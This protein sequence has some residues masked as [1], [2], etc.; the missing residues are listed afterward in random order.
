MTEDWQLLTDF[1]PARWQELAI[2]TDATKG[3]RKN[4]PIDNLLRVLLIHIACGCSLRETV[5]RAKKAQLAEMSDVALLKRLR[6]CKEWL[7]S[8]CIEIFIE[9]GV[10]INDVDLKF[11]LF[12]ATHVQEPGK[13][14]S[15]WRVH[16]SFQVPDM[17][18]DFF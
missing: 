3:L 10:P 18:C 11:R 5:A 12:D 9:F 14:G 8:L 7:Y 1:F 4:K 13:T 2:Q 17:R 15:L 16:Y 6:K